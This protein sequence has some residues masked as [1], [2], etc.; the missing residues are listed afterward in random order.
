MI[1]KYEYINSLVGVPFKAGGREKSGMDCYGLLLHVWREVH[2]IAL[3]DWSAT[4]VTDNVIKIMQGAIQDQLETGSGK[5]IE[6]PE[7]WCV[8]VVRHRTAPYHLG[9]HI[10]GGVLHAVNPDG[11]IFQTLGR[12][13]ANHDPKLVE[14]YKWQQ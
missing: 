10:A 7:E 11:V 9:I 12:F 2:D 6:Q 5:R 1:D 4:Y 3:P 13:L 14:F 8:V